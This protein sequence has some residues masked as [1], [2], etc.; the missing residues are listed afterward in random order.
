MHSREELT[1]D[2][3]SDHDKEALECIPTSNQ[4]IEIS[5]TLGWRMHEY[6]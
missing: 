2:S 3:V 1:N 6:C 4:V 5:E